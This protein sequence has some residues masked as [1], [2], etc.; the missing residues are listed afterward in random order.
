MG[1]YTRDAGIAE[2]QDPRH[3][4]QR[5][6]T[7]DQVDEAV[8]LYADGKSL[9]RIDDHFGVDHTAVWQQ[10]KMRG[11]KMRDSHGREK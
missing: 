7:D 4:R 6:L 2:T 9:Y 8:K 5:G 11:V 10:L 3:V 1:K